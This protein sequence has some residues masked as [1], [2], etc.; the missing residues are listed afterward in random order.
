MRGGNIFTPRR[1]FAHD[2][3]APAQPRQRAG[4]STAGTRVAQAPGATTRQP[5]RR[6]NGFFFPSQ[7]LLSFPETGGGAPGRED[8]RTRPTAPTRRAAGFRQARAMRGRQWQ[9]LPYPHPSAF[10]FSRTKA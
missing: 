2:N 4:H 1:N 5:R 9:D 7:L 6:P 3:R 10:W 8:H